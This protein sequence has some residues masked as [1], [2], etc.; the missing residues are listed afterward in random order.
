M[1]LSRI[2]QKFCIYSN[3]KISEIL[4]K[5]AR[6]LELDKIVTEVKESEEWEAVEMNILEIGIE[7]GI[8]QG[9]QEGIKA[10]IEICCESGISR[11]ETADKIAEK[12]SLEEETAKEYISK[13][14]KDN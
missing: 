6:I 14:W 11:Q 7:K 13:Y 10:A 12:F 1:G 3:L 9:K 8:E 2:R 5:D 4:V